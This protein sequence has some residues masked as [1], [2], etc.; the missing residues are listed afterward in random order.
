MAKK[1]VEEKPVKSASKVKVADKLKKTK[2]TAGKK[3]L[4]S[5]IQ[6]DAKASKKAEAKKVPKGSLKGKDHKITFKKNTKTIARTGDWSVSDLKAADYNPR[7][8][9]SKEL[10]NLGQSIAEFGD[11]SGVVFNRFS[12]QL[13]SGHQRISSMSKYKSVIKTSPVKGDKHGTVEEGHILFKTEKGVVRVPIR[14]VEWSSLKNEGAANIAA[15]AHGGD[16]DTKRLALLVGEIGGFGPDSDPNLLGLGLE[17]LKSLQSFT[18]PTD[19]KSSAPTNGKFAE[20]DAD[21]I[22]QEMDCKCPQCG[23]LFKKA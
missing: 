10:A 2:P 14:I 21:E 5:R 3:D 20:F 8:I 9:T 12:G 22:Q 17:Q 11:L 18:V 7:N 13:V 19:A 15:N 4:S 16:F 1:K 6:K 23:F